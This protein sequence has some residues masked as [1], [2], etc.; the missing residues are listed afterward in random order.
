[1]K[2]KKKTIFC[3]ETEGCYLEKTGEVTDQFHKKFLAERIFFGDFIEVVKIFRGYFLKN[4]YY[5]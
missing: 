2:V 3:E 1:M 4:D 5:K